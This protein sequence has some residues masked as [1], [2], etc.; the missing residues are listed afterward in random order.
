ML[1]IRNRARAVTERIVAGA[2]A[3]EGGPRKRASRIVN[4]HFM[5]VVL[6]PPMLVLG[7][8]VTL[9]VAYLLWTSVHIPQQFTPDQF[10]GLTHYASIFSDPNFWE[11][12]SHSLRYV[13]GSVSIAFVLGLTAALS[14]NQLKSELWRGVATVLILLAWAVPLVVTGL[15]WRFMLHSNYGIINGILVY[16]GAIIEPIGFTTTPAIAFVSIV[17]VD[18][19]AR[20]PFAAIILLAGLQ[21]IPADLYEAATIDGANRLQQFLH[22]TLPN[23]KGQAAIALLIMSMFAFRTF[24]IVYAI[25]GGGPADATRVL[26]VYIYDVGISQSRLG[27]A[28]ALSVVMILM[29]LVFVAAY[30]LRVQQ[31]A[32]ETEVAA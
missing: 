21:T 1:S 7:T 11:S 18:A 8:L 27:Y 15:I 24:S 25:T 2:Q 5:L 12:L 30:V 20:A 19:W 14:I 4:R 9:P 31:E 13:A 28:S 29:T 26:A 22:I 32:V 17:I 16:M 6:T 10:V 23:I 3:S